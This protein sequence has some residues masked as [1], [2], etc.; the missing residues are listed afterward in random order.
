ME[1]EERGEGRG[2]GRGREKQNGYYRSLLKPNCSHAQQSRRAS[3]STWHSS[4]PKLRRCHIPPDI[5]QH[6]K[7]ETHFTTRTSPCVSCVPC[8]LCVSCV[9]CAPCASRSCAPSLAHPS[10]SQVVYG[11]GHKSYM[12][13]VT[14]CIGGGG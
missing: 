3:Y 5:L 2:R 10:A 4:E 8:M 9:P 1:G 12:G 14:E 6:I 13:M 11:N 7:V